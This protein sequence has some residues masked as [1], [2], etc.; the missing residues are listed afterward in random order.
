MPPGICRRRPARKPVPLNG[1]VLIHQHPRLVVS[2]ELLRVLRI[3]DGR[4]DRFGEDV[5]DGVEGREG[6]RDW[7]GRDGDPCGNAFGDAVVFA[8]ALLDHYIGTALIHRQQACEF[9]E[10][11]AIKV[12]FEFLDEI[13][14]KFIFNDLYLRPEWLSATG[15]L[16]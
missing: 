2:Y 15:L 8:L 13:G 16:L 6:G 3:E 7:T 14:A 1:A 10:V 5:S 9:V 4:D 11:V 12:F